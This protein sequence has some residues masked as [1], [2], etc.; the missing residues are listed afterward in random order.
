MVKGKPKPISV[1]QILALQLKRVAR[2]GCQVYSV[3]VE[4]L[5]QQPEEN[6]LET[7]PV[8]REFKDV[9][10]DEIPHLP[11]RREIN[12]SIELV[13]GETPVSRAPY[14]MSTLEL[15]ELKMQ[16]QEYGEHQHCF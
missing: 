10:L 5:R 9:F 8:I 1:R 14:R 4:E 12:F 2:N 11:P 7:L 3:H 13:M 16:L 15:M 6:P